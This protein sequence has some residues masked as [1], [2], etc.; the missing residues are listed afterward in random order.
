MTSTADALRYIADN[1]SWL[2]HHPD[3]DQAFD[4]LEHIAALVDSAIDTTPPKMYAGPCDVCRKDM[5]ADPEAGVVE[6]KVCQLVYPMEGR[7][8]HLLSLVADQLDTAS[9]ISA[10]IADL[11]EN[12][13]PEVIRKWAQR[14]R[15]IAKGRDHRGHP[16]Y[17]VGDVLD[18]RKTMKR[19]A[20]S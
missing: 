17:R 13:T 6:C 18:L 19:R 15:L 9:N 12:V 7:R 11:G 2:A 3:A 8:D 1:T 16:T 10:A 20:A 4:E 14:G 5:Y